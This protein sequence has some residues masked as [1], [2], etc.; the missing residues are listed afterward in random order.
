MC[1]TF[2]C[3][4]CS[5]N[6]KN[7]LQVKLYLNIHLVQLSPF[8]SD[9]RPLVTLTIN[10]HH[11]NTHY[12]TCFS[13]KQVS[14]VL[15]GKLSALRSKYTSTDLQAS[16]H[17]L[18]SASQ[19]HVYSSSAKQ[20]Q[21]HLSLVSKHKWGHKV[22]QNNSTSIFISTSLITDILKKQ[23]KANWLKLKLK[24]SRLSMSLSTSRRSEQLQGKLW[25]WG[26]RGKSWCHVI[27]Q[28]KKKKKKYN[29]NIFP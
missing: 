2:C 11:D 29:Q 16:E 6:I 28:K 10:L 1:L 22:C 7:T 24:A 27:W 19:P 8:T 5:P 20:L 15:P 4:S 14:R 21:A 26:K 9:H 3:F 23:T 13:G 12:P 18:C 17:F 25:R